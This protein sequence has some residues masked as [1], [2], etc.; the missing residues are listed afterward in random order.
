MITKLLSSR[1]LLTQ[2]LV[3]NLLA[4]IIL[5]FFTF[6][7]L[8]AIQPELVSKQSDKHLRIIKNI[9]AN[10]NIKKI[11]IDKESLKI[12]LTEYKY[13][14]DEIDQIRFVDK[15][16]NILFDSIFL[17]IDQNVF[18]KTSPI[19]QIR[20]N[21]KEENLKIG[22]NNDIKKD[23]VNDP[24]FKKYTQKFKEENSFSVFELLKKNFIV[25]TFFNLS[26]EN[27]YPLSTREE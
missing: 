10:L 4:F 5:G 15:N 2:F 1:S 6:L 20:L 24:F 14:F 22:E 21:D 9:E 18:L 12:F 27:K 8:K 17:D 3:F 19:D 23:L 11:N 13:L 25:H 7:Y 16:N 26:L